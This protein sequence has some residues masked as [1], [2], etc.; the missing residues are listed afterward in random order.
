MFRVLVSSLGIPAVAATTVVPVAL[1]TSEWSVA[2]SFAVVALV[3]GLAS[4]FGRRQL[5]PLGDVTTVARL[6]LV[7]VVW[8]LIAVVMS[9]TTFAAVFVAP[10]SG[11][12]PE[13]SDL[14]SAAFESVSGVSTTGLSM[15]GDSAAADPWLQWWRSVLQWIGAIGVVGFAAMLAE[16]SGDHDALVESVWA[17]A[18][19]SGAVGIVRRLVAILATITAVAAVGL[20]AA[21]EPVW[22]ALNHAMTAAATGGF[23]VTSDSAST[24]PAPARIVLAVSVDALARKAVSS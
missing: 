2:S 17:D 12:A 8:I 11:G 23:S 21:G 19:G 13:L 5:E 20:L 22:H 10:E 3:T 14:W 7:A 4:F 16:P 9:A 1:A 18:P 6:S 24:M 15:L